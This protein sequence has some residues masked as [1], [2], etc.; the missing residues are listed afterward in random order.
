MVL[1][2]LIRL[3]RLG[4]RVIGDFRKKGDEEFVEIKGGIEEE[5]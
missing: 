5:E 4:E 1:D 2:L 3:R